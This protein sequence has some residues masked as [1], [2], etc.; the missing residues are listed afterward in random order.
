M[1]MMRILIM[2]P[3]MTMMMTMTLTLLYDAGHDACKG[4]NGNCDDDEMTLT[5]TT[6]IAMT[7]VMTTP[8]QPQQSEP[9]QPPSPQP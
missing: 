4:D 9:L 8:E 1:L 7:M 3:V 2:M 5:V 6:P